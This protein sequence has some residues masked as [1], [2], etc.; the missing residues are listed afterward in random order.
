MQNAPSLTAKNVAL[1]RAAHQLMEGGTIFPDPL[2]VWMPSLALCERIL[3]SIDYD[4]SRWP[5]AA[6][7]RIALRVL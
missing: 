2:A 1:L 3:S 4:C 7:R 5:A 6:S